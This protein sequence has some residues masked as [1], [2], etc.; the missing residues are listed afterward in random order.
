MSYIYA[1]SHLLYLQCI[2]LKHSSSVYQATSV[3]V[4]SFLYRLDLLSFHKLLLH[5]PLVYFY[6]ESDYRLCPFACMESPSS[7]MECFTFIIWY[8]L[9][10]DWGYDHEW[11]ASCCV[12]PQPQQNIFSIFWWAAAFDCWQLYPKSHRDHIGPTGFKRLS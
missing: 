9:V 8:A 2:V 12:L 4:L 3:Y 6:K 1:K 10:L 5:V 7:N 11:K